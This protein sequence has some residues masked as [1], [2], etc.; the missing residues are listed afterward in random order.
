M[1]REMNTGILNA[2]FQ[3]IIHIRVTMDRYSRCSCIVKTLWMNQSNYVNNENTL[4]I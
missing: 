1:D 2:P 4:H 3:I